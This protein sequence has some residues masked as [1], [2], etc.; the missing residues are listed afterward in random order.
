MVRLIAVLAFCLLALFRPLFFR[1]DRSMLA[2]GSND[3]TVKL[4]DVGGAKAAAR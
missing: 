3:D 4:W 2:S 1:P